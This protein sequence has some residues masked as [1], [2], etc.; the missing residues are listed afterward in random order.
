MAKLDVMD[1][2]AHV[3]IGRLGGRRVGTQVKV[4]GDL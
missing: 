1:N 2:V 3:G 4:T